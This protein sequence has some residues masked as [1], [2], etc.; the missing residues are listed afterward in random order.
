[1]GFHNQNCF[2]LGGRSKLCRIAR[3]R[4]LEGGMKCLCS[5]EKPPAKADPLAEAKAMD[6]RVDLL[7]SLELLEYAGVRMEPRLEDRKHT[8][9]F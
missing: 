7:K 2:H 9:E 8:L 3:L 4:G 5:L 1:M 6:V